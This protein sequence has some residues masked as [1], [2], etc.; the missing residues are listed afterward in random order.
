[1]G[2]TPLSEHGESTLPAG[3]LDVRGWPVRTLADEDEVGR[4]DDLLINQAGAV[5]YLDVML[6]R[7]RKHV[8]LPWSHARVDRSEHVVW[9][10][11]MTREQFEDIP[12]YRHDVGGVT[13][14]YEARLGAVYGGAWSSVA[15]QEFGGGAR[16]E[17]V[18]GEEDGRLASLGELEDFDVVDEDPDPRGWEVIAADGRVIGSVHELIVDTT[19][20]KVRYLDCG[21]DEEA[22]GLDREGRHILVPVGYARLDEANENVIVDAISSAD[23]RNLPAY[24]GLPVTRAYEEGLR[25]RFTGSIGGLED[26]RCGTAADE[27][28]GSRL[29]DGG[30]S[31]V[32]DPTREG[33]TS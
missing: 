10:P 22:L 13:P 1:M 15:R 8:L 9:V 4:V 12:E 14:D 7:F 5:R 18:G 33:S 28:G 31:N 27:R 25:T 11:G 16:A 29:S 21:V 20:L 2:L 23:V 3:T 19:A 30:E 6:G 17:A 26:E 32:S 24:G